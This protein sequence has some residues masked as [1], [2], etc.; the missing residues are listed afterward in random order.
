MGMGCL[1]CLELVLKTKAP[2]A[3]VEGAL[4]HIAFEVVGFHCTGAGQPENQRAR[5]NGF[6]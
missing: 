3:R 2:I 4:G 5:D 6:V 1:L